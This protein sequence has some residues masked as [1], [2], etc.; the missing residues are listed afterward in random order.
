MPF[1]P[2]VLLLAWQAVSRSASFALGWATSLFFG[3][4]PGSK[5]RLLSIMALISAAW[6]VVVLG[7]AL[8]IAAGWAAERFGVVERNFD[9]A[10]WQTWGLVGA[11]VITPPVV[12]GLAEIAGFDGQRSI[13]NWLGR[14][15]A[16]YPGS[17][18]LGVAVLLMMVIT[19]FLLIQRLR[20]K[21]VL[22]P[23]P[24]VLREGAD[25]ASVTDAIV[26]AL[27]A[28]GLGRFERRTLTGPRSWPLRAMGFAARHLLGTLVRGEPDRMTADGMEV[29]A[30]A[31][32]V[33]VL[34]P[35]EDA[36]R[37]RAAIARSLAFSDAYLT[38]S[39]DSQA[40]ED[41]LADLRRAREQGRDISREI[42]QFRATFDAASLNADEWNVLERLRLQLVEEADA[43]ASVAPGER[44]EAGLPAEAASPA[45]DEV[46][47]AAR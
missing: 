6:V 7:F 25:D 28:A 32:N 2:F 5:G 9:L 8:P 13:G 42:D 16:A 19:P 31:T 46:A 24:V 18:S 36:Y 45:R 37:A 11:V 3:Y 17:A 15:P 22:L 27:D 35:Q 20:Q 10:W 47:A 4:V 34:G 14:V 43:D 26:A 30:Y 41:E 39:A 1:L 40:L 23:I 44:G 33:A 12:A 38:W 29:M 21:K